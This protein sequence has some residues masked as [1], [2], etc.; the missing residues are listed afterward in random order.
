MASGHGGNIKELAGEAGLD[1]EEILDF[2]AN[3]NPLGPPEWLRPTIS[4]LVENVSHYP[5]PESSA[6]V[7]TVALH[8]DISPDEVIAGNGTSQLIFVLCRALSPQ[9]TVLP[10]PCYIDYARAARLAESRVTEVQIPE[11]NGFRPDLE[12][13]ATRLGAGEVVFIGQPNNPTGLA[14]DPDE[15]RSLARNNP[16]TVVVVD[17]AFA[18]FPAVLNSMIDDRPPNV[19]VLRSMTKFYAVPGLRLGYAVADAALAD[20]VRELLPP[21]SMNVF[22]QEVG[23][24]ALMDV[25]YARQTRDLV[26]VERKHLGREL[27]KLGG[28]TVYPGRANFLMVRIDRP[29]MAAPELA[30]ELLHRDGIAIRVCENFTGLD[31][32][33]F[34]L[35]VR[36]REENDR[37]IAALSR[38]MGQSVS[39]T[40]H[41]RTP[42]LMF[43]GTG[44]S[45][46]KS[47]L[48]AALCRIL[49]QKGLDVAPFKAQNM[50]LN[51]FVTPDGCEIGRA[52][53]M[54]AQ[55]GRVE[56]DVRMNPVLL[57]PTSETGSQVIVDGHPVGNMSVDEYIRYKPEASERARAAYDSLADEFDAVVMEGAGSPAEINL[58]HHDIVNMAMARHADAPVLLVGDI[59]RGGVFASFVGSM[60]VL[61][62]W[63]RDLVGGFV[64]NKFR[65]DA[66]LLSPAFEYVLGHTGRPVLGAV[67]YI[68][69]LGL[70][71]EDSVEFKSASRTDASTAEA[72]IEVALVD[73]PHVSNFTDLDPLR[74]EPDVQVRVVRAGDEVGE[75]DALVLPGSKNVVDDLQALRDSGIA[76]QIHTLAAAGRTEVVGI[77]GGFQM[78][79]RT[80]AD[81]HGIESS[82]GKARGL[83]LLPVKTILAAGKTLRRVRGTHLPSGQEIHGY[84]IHHG[85]TASS[86][87][88]PMARSEEGRVLGAAAP[89][90]H[91]WGTYVHGIF[92][93]DGFRR[94]FV[95]RLRT[96]RGLK[97]LREIQ[98]PYDLEPAF[99]RLADVVRENLHLGR[100]LGL[101]GL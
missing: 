83:G 21:W 37:L 86:E 25:E 97:P 98:T 64:I 11:H 94:W 47:V 50:S 45:A 82:A 93:A 72:V 39:Q 8:H 57:K 10:V 52:Q 74:G 35:A 12:G 38:A 22:A 20:K 48:T 5:D 41:R 9:R 40:R 60:E 63:E 80:I 24:R 28:M 32:R 31:E 17:E 18:D 68:E 42:A 14:V 26:E 95:D 46:G 99:D 71:Q 89:G 7:Q 88:S 67:P 91:I 56:V 53:A 16:D 34:R 30:E 2:S 59:D 6:F 85:E 75:P 96:R 84:E 61:A 36:V 79:G 23:R 77:C 58:K 3:I 15:L 65:G 90:D 100:I 87:A 4:R 51:S 81:P 62:E 66:S 55:A 33:F 19:V 69:E 29:D 92:D 49:R 78:L 43:Q 54:Q 101:M 27:K 73:L 1:E 70:P 44:S 13:L 76:D